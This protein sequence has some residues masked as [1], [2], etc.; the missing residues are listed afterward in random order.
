MKKSFSNNSKIF[1]AGCTG[2][3]G[4][5]IK[6]ALIKKGY[7]NLFA[8]DRNELNLFDID[9]VKTW[10]IKNKP[11]IVI[12]AAAKVGGILAN[13]NYPA[14]FLIENLK[15]QSNIIQSAW[16]TGVRRLLFL[17]SSCI[18]PKYA[19]QPIKEEFLLESFLER[20]NEWYA[21]AKITGLKL[22]ESLRIQYGFDAISLM[23][24]NLYGPNDN[25]HPDNSHVVASLIRK[26]IIAKTNNLPEVI[27]WG[28]GTVLRE[29]LH[30]D[31]L[32]EAVIFCLAEW[33][34]SNENSPKDSQGNALN[35][36][37]V[38]TGKDIT[39]IELAELIS[40]IVDYKGKILWDKTK[41][42]GTPRKLLDVSRIN[43]LGWKARID[44]ETGLKE[45]IKCL[46]LEKL[47]SF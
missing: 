31:D 44:L 40:K 12:I 3:V 39:I 45:T 26:F 47:N 42:D 24:T 46:S 20:S 27:C 28:T 34:P 9:L 1:L 11:E 18:Y 37:N 13:S 7:T 25:Y 35:H 32:A 19:K 38:G 4:S 10:F 6:R 16:E 33:H 15:I 36:L 29:F 5:S 41:P 30:V 17:G 23:P 14:D 22:C 2:M 21:I 8:P 43:D